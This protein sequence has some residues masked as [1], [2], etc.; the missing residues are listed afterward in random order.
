M[1]FRSGVYTDDSSGSSTNTMDERLDENSDDDDESGI[2][3]ADEKYVEVLLNISQ[4]ARSPSHNV[5]HLGWED[6]IEGWGRPTRSAS[7]ATQKKN[8]KTKPTDSEYHCVLCLKPMQFP[9]CPDLQKVDCTQG[10]KKRVESPPARCNS[11]SKKE[12]YSIKTNTMQ[13]SQPPSKQDKNQP[14]VCKEKSE[15]ADCCVLKE[16]QYIRNERPAQCL[17]TRDNV[18]H[19]GLAANSLAVLPPIK[20]AISTDVKSPTTPVRENEIIFID[21]GNKMGNVDSDKTLKESSEVKAAEGN[22]E[23]TTLS[24]LNLNKSQSTE[25]SSHSF[26]TNHHMQSNTAELW[27]WQSPLL[28]AKDAVTAYRIPTSKKTDSSH[29]PTK[30]LHQRGVHVSG[31]N[32]KQEGA[33][34]LTFQ[35]NSQNQQLFT[36]NKS[37]NASRG[38]DLPTQPTLPMLAGTRVPIPTSPYRLF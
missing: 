23:V 21:S 6:A 25:F 31:N 32:M 36:G 1:Y 3:H 24:P 11:A 35:K 8:I 16:S 19:E 7:V 2:C 30:V 20:Q 37:K 4:E 33:R 5:F 26:I 13:A 22:D 18:P 29:N 15:E 17:S 38:S 12:T 28:D 27:H 34:K 10:E 14:V 9:E